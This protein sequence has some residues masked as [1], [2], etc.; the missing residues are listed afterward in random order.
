MITHKQIRDIKSAVSGICM[1]MGLN[2]ASDYGGI[3]TV[4]DILLYLKA[5]KKKLPV[6]RLADEYTVC[7]EEEKKV[8]PHVSSQFVKSL[9][10]NKA[11]KRRCND[12]QEVFTKKI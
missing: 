6:K 1:Q 7:I 9:F 8:C 3:K 4:E 11:Q 5:I 10:N 2:T 12:C